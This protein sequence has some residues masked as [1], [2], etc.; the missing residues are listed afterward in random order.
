MQLPA[1]FD[2]G[3]VGRHQ[4]CFCQ[5]QDARTMRGRS[6]EP[7][8]CPGLQVPQRRLAENKGRHSRESLGTVRLKGRIGRE[9]PLCEG[10]ANALIVK[11]KRFESPLFRADLILE[12]GS[13]AAA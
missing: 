9:Q 3:A 2:T 10:F 11:Q 5:A 13:A 6:F 8:F 1:Q 7:D 4:I 12:F